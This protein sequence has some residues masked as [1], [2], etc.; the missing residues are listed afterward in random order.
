MAREKT[1]GFYTSMTIA[2]PMT[3]RLSRRELLSVAGAVLPVSL[4][5]L[6]VASFAQETTTGTESPAQPV[7]AAQQFS[8]DILSEEMRLLAQQPHVTAPA[9]EGFLGDLSYDDYRLIR[10][11]DDI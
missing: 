3:S 4:L 10:F 9:P 5:A 7:A 11:R 6:P 1:V 8:F 2:G